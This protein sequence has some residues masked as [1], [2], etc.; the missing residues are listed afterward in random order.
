[1]LIDF[2]VSNFR[3][4]RDRQNLS[5]YRSARTL[6]VARAEE[7][8]WLRPDVSP[9][10]AIYGANA[11]GKSSVLD[12][13]GF[14]S[15]A[16]EDSYARWDADGG[17]P[18]QPFKLDRQHRTMPTEFDIEFLA[19]DGNEYRYGFA[20][21][22]ERVLSE[23]LHV[24]RTRRRSILF[25][26]ERDSYKFGDSFRGPAS[27]LRE[28]TRPNA[29][30]LSA[31][32][33]ARLEATEP[34]H[35][36]LTE[37]LSFYHATGF[38]AEHNRIK[39]LLARDADFADQIT[40]F[41]RQLDLG[42]QSVSVVKQEMDPE[43]RERIRQIIDARDDELLTF[44]DVIGTFET[45][46]QLSHQG[47]GERFELPFNV[48]SDGTQALISFASVAIRAL[49]EGTVC[50]VDEIDSSLHPLMVAE[51]IAVFADARVNR[52]Q[53]QLIITTH[54]VSLLRPG[55]KL[56][57]DAVWVVEKNAVGASD[58]IPI[59]DFGLPRKDENLERA[60]L[61]GR[62]GGLPMSSLVNSMLEARG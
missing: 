9:V 24:Y 12:A 47:D 56:E 43:E 5:M 36:W 31:S 22:D 39:R 30:F 32:A 29:L 55:T 62:Y 33:A 10:A 48:E 53:A 16:V 17:V 34:A 40:D 19:A 15:R 44:D 23:Y 7:D 49:A 57:S 25:E 13:L 20:V 3:S 21:D 35:D 8:P 18:R 58:L 14:V 52:K 4:L 51:L 38:P 54:D 41:M 42:V 61:T 27:L 28:T 1:M 11:A 26:R 50:V 37:R 59:R 2:T 45:E 6:K 60:Y 46:L